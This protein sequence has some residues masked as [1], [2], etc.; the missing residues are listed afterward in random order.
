MNFKNDFI[1]Q[2]KGHTLGKKTGR[3]LLVMMKIFSEIF[4]NQGSL[5]E[6]QTCLPLVTIQHGMGLTFITHKDYLAF[7]LL[8][9]LFHALVCK[10]V[11]LNQYD[12]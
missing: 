2:E 11:V 12:P 7:G 10:Q 5:A 3:L 8:A 1:C 9:P 6:R 4:Q